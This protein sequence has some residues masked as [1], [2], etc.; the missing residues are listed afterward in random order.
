MTRLIR[1]YRPLH[2]RHVNRIGL[3]RLARLLVLVVAV[4]VVVAAAPAPA[5]AALDYRDAVDITFP[6]RGSVRYSNDFANPRSGGR[7]H[8]ATDVFAAKGLPV[9][10]ARGGTVI[11]LPTSETGLSGYAIQILGDDGR[12][13]AYYHLGPHGG[14]F[15][16][17]IAKGIRLGGSVTRGQRIGFVGDSGNAAGGTSHVHLELH[18]NRITDPYGSNR[19]NPYASLR[20]AQGLSSGREGPAP[21]PPVASGDAVLR[22][23]SRGPAVETWQR[24]LNRTRATGRLIVDASFG[25]ATHAATVTF[26]KSVGLG[27]DGLGVVGPKT[28]GAMKRSLVHNSP[29]K[30]TSPRK[31]RRPTPRPPATTEPIAGSQLLKLGSTGEAVLRWQRK[32][33]RSGRTNRIVSDGSFGPA[34]HN[35]TVNFQKSV[36]LGPLGLGVVGPKTRAAMRRAL[37]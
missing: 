12:T 28:R 4:V 31:P 2:A 13:Y 5:V 11:W 30:P 35:A 20:R 22:L 26:Q 34:T 3:M 6:V 19:I 1:P 8:R 18:D 27:P 9:L 17:A 10:A 24:Q 23:G 29:P 7:V 15:R 33:N 32:L 36:G 37:N 21:A 25:P 16:Q 14:R